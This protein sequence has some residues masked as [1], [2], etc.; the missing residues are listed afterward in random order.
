MNI[1]YRERPVSNLDS[2]SRYVE[3]R[4]GIAKG[5]H[6]FIVDYDDDSQAEWGVK[7]TYSRMEFPDGEVSVVFQSHP[8]VRPNVTARINEH[9]AFELGVILVRSRV[10][11]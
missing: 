4:G 2:L 3:K 10:D 8:E 6:W 9:T 5:T 1:L 7:G 11:L